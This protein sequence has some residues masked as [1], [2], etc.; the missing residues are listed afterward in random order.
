L[1]HARQDIVAGKDMRVAL[2]ARRRCSTHQAA[3]FAR[4]II[5]RAPIRNVA[6]DTF[7]AYS[8]VNRRID[9]ID[10]GVEYGMEN[11]FCLRLCDVTA[12]WRATEFHGTVAQHGDLESRASEF[13]L[14]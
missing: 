11:G 10:A 1:F 7:F 6:P 9:I 8:I 5:F 14:G 12:T 13:P 2:A 4:E 3:A